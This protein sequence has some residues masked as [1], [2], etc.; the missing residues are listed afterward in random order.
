V[1]CMLAAALLAA[2]CGRPA[3][4]DYFPLG[5][6]A[7]WE[8]AISYKVRGERHTQRLIFSNG[9]PVVV[10]DKRYYPRIGL[11]GKREYFRRTDSGILHVDP[12]S[13]K[14]SQ[15][16]KFP[17]KK[18]QTWQADSK[19]KVL[20]VTGAFTPTFRARIIN[21]VTLTYRIEDSDDTVS[22]AAGTFRHCLRIRSR[23]SLFAGKTLQQ[24]MGINSID[25]DQT[26]WYAP[27]VGL[28]KTVR[29][30]YTAPG[31][32]KNIYTRELVSYTSG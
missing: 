2:A 31:E 18:G 3:A 16:L 7:A 30:E 27:G 13:G 11:S 25:I 22:V 19:I 14:Q 1:A 6:G 20:E 17:L 4:G 5:K 12:V 10:N 26:E 8:Y 23:G 9:D 24:F 21:P 32:F 15:V 29:Q 28:V